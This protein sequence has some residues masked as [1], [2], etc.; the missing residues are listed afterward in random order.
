MSVAYKIM[1]ILALSF[2]PSKAICSVSP[3]GMELSKATSME[4]E[5]KYKVLS[6]EKY[7]DG[8]CLDIDPSALEVEGIKQASFT[9]NDKD[10][11]E[12][13][14][15]TMDKSK[16]EEMREILG[17]KYKLKEEE[18]PPVGNKFSSFTSGNNLITIIARHMSFDLVLVYTTK[19]RM[20][21]YMKKKNLQ[22]NL[23]RDIKK[24]AF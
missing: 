11:L 9:F 17:A 4:V 21:N 18:V 24:A 10:I 15:V 12:T 7:S 2:I 16:F 1:V 22:E 5:S 8:L 6:R 13:V 23:D 20:E 3:F 14:V 19:N